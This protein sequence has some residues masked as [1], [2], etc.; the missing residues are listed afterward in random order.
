M[1]PAFCAVAFCSSSYTS[2]LL[3][4]HSKALRCSISIKALLPS[5]EGMSGVQVWM[6]G[7]K[8][9][10]AWQRGRAKWPERIP[11]AATPL[12]SSQE[13]HTRLHR[14]TAHLR[15]LS[16]LWHLQTTFSRSTA[17]LIVKISVY[18]QNLPLLSF[19]FSPLENFVV[20]QTLKRC[21]ALFAVR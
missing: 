5:P 6:F 20:A 12:K 8:G 4:L 10:L 18:G 3:P 11:V 21:W 17:R 14:I 13:P 9:D 1:N 15:C 16:P 7:K 19:Q 2:F